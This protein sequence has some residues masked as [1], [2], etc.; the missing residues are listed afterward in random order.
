[1][2]PA[3]ITVSAV[4]SMILP[5]TANTLDEHPVLGKQRFGFLHRLAHNQ[6]PVLD[7][8]CAQLELVPGRAGTARFLLAPMLFLVALARRLEIDAEQGRAE[9]RENECGSDRAENVGDGVGDRHRVQELLGFLRRQAEAVDR[10]GRKAHRCRDR[11]RTGIKP[12]GGADVIAGQLGADISCER[13]RTRRPPRQTT[14]A[15]FRPCAMPRT[16]CGPTP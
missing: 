6:A 8:E 3:W 13:D 9:Q 16:N 11:L 7:A 15:E 2:S 1:M 5:L 14:P 12:R 4:A 10:V